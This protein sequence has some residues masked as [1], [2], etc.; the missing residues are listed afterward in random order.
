M[1]SGITEQSW[2]PIAV[3][4]L[5][6]EVG[7]GNPAALRAIIFQIRRDCPE[8]EVNQTQLTH[9]TIL[10]NLFHKVMTGSVRLSG[11]YTENGTAV[12]KGS[13]ARIART[14]MGLE[15]R[16]RRIGQTG[17]SRTE[18]R[19]TEKTLVAVQEMALQSL[20]PEQLQQYSQ[21]YLL[22]PDVYGK[23]PM[24]PAE[25]ERDFWQ[26]GDIGSME[27]RSLRPIC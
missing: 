17:I 12:R 21:V 9:S 22:I 5:V 1:H 19:S 14:L 2:H 13:T 11:H 15:L 8:W 25:E 24:I 20:P 6:P 16:L 10:P 4:T 7:D 23:L 27:Q 18:A 26:K 3:D